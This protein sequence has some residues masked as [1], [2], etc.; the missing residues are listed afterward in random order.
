MR[1]L[2]FILG[3]IISLMSCSPSRSEIRGEAGLHDGEEE[4]FGGIRSKEALDDASVKG[5]ILSST[6]H[7]DLSC[8]GNI[9]PAAPQ[10][11]QAKRRTPTGRSFFLRDGKVINTNNFTPFFSVIF[12]KESGRLSCER[13]IFSICFLRL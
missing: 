6:G 11:Q 5:F 4:I 8:G 3:L 10:T 2:I 1:S 12:L 7:A 9:L 13:Y